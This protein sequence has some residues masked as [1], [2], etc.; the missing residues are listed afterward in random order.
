MANATFFGHSMHETFATFSSYARGYF[1][2][3][4]ISTFTDFVS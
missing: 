2:Q 1:D 3:M 4:I